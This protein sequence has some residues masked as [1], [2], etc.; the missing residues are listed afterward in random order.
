M[1]PFE[2]YQVHLAVKAHFT[3]PSYDYKKYNGKT[4]AKFN[5]FA[6]SK[7]KYFYGKLGKKYKKD[8]PEFLATT[9]AY[10]GDNSWIGD[11]DSEESMKAWEEHQ[12]H[13]QSIKRV[14]SKDVDLILDVA[15]KNELS[16]KQMFKAKDGEL[17][18]IEKL[19]QIDLITIETCVI[20]NRLLGYTTKT[21]STNP[22]W[23]TIIITI[24]KYDTF[25]KL[26]TLGEFATILKSKL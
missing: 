9:Y 1:E 8:L 21:K 2:A 11:F 7:G 4:N 10:L 18:P 5:A 19:R 3:R 15:G 17:P 25:L 23:E 12:K 16:F 20:L 26:P 13:M 6:K 14:F 22:L 24:E